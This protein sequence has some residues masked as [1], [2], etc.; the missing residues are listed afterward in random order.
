MPNMRTK[1]QVGVARADEDDVFL[2]E[3]WR[4]G[5]HELPGDSVASPGK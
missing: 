5:V 3:D 1:T 2:K 4:S